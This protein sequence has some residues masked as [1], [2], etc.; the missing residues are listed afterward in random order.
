[1]GLSEGT[2]HPEPVEGSGVDEGEPWLAFGGHS[3]LP[4][5]RRLASIRIYPTAARFRFWKLLL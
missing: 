2:R 5:E 1:M 4:H 3:N